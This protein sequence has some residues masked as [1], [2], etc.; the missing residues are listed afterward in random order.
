M[1]Y[2]FGEVLFFNVV[3]TLQLPRLI[4]PPFL[5]LGPIGIIGGGADII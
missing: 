2:Q 5:N 1:S 4:A 3:L